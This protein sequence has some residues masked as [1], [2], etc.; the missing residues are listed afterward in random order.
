MLA[1][2]SLLFGL[3]YIASW[4]LVFFVPN[5]IYFGRVDEPAL[6]HRFGDR[7]RLYKANVPCWVLRRRLRDVP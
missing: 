6:E 1:A 3:S 7:Y 2:E 5:V 4:M